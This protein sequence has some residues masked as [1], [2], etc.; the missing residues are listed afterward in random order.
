MPI[1]T[2]RRPLAAVAVTAAAAL[3]LATLGLA[4]A[5]TPTDTLVIADKIDD[6][7]SLDPAESFEFSGNDLLNNAYDTLV[8]L[9]PT[10]LGPLV[11]GLAESWSVAEDGV[12]YTFRIRE[13]VTFH[14]GNPV[15]AEDAAWS[16]HRAVKLDKTPSFILTQFGFTPDNVDQMI[17]AT[18]PHE[19]TI[20]TDR[21]YAP[22]FFYNC[23]TAV[24]ASVVDKAEALSHEVEGDYG[25]EWLK[26]HTAGSGA[27]SLR[28][29]KPSD[30]YVM[31]ANEDFWRGA[32]P[33]KRVFVRHVPEASTQRLLLE[34]GDVDIARKLTPTDVEGI[35][36]NEE[37]AVT[38]EVRGQI[39]Y[40][41]LNQ[42]V[43]ALSNPKV[44]EAFKYLVDY[45]GMAGSFLKGQFMVHQAF[46]PKGFLGAIED[47]PYGLDVEKAKE[48]LAEAGVEDLQVR[49]FVRNDQDRLEVAQALQNTWAQAGIQAELRV[50]TGAEILTD[51]RARKHDIYLGDWGPDY[52]DPHT[53]ADTFARNPDNSDEAGL[54]GI[55]AW[56]NAWPADEV[57]EITDMAVLERDG[58]K[59]AAM[60]GEIQRLHQTFS[61]FVV[62]FQRIEQVASRRNVAGFSA[63]GSIHSAF[64]WNVTKE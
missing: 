17:R 28:A 47:R 60:Y 13:G 63:G 21:S 11:P 51:Y 22:T 53:N 31:E 37:V 56:R 57:E 19:L 35:A 3:G 20:V 30:S 6:I 29:Y 39:R 48:L 64:Y 55:L 26:T 49:I 1:A 54:T 8:E 25:Y 44:V 14:S 43:E 36:G 18:G 52:P 12:T 41:S 5:E 46:L 23:L 33:L 9:D 61:P 4:R 10:D 50:G 2:L 15:T 58:E 32:P 59:R 42:K 34:R 40:L 24:V 38:D 7:V 27:Y 62:M 16:L 45:D